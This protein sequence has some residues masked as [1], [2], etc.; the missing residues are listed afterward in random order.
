MIKKIIGAL[1]LASLLSGCA[2]VTIHPKKT[3]KLASTPSFEESKDFFF[4]GLSGEH[5]L[6][7]AEVCG[8]KP[9][10]QMQSQATF[11][12]VVLTIVTLGIYAPHSV[13]VWC[14]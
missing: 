7:V 10:N 4:W 1:V 12:D 2:T 14:E 3:Q 8:N 5:R 11:N 6:N 9:V 13:K